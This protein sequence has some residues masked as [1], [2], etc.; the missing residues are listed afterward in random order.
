MLTATMIR[1]MA[2]SPWSPTLAWKLMEMIAEEAM[3]PM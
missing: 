1:A 2:W 3:E